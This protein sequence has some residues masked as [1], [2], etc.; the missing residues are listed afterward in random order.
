M[1]AGNKIDKRALL[2]LYLQVAA[3]LR[4]RITSGE[5]SGMLPGQRKLAASY[6]VSPGTLIKALDVL[7]AEGLVESWK[8]RGTG[9]VE[10]ERRG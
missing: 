7:K 5:L 6:G 4:Q 9:V 3:L 10:P 8:G 2:P 1:D